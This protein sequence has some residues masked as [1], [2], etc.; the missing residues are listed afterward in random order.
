MKKIVPSIFCFLC[1]FSLF[2]LEPAF[3]Q[4][5]QSDFKNF[6]VTVPIKLDLL[7]ATQHGMFNDFFLTDQSSVILLPSSETTYSTHLAIEA[8]LYHNKA[9]TIYRSFFARFSFKGSVEQIEEVSLL[10]GLRWKLGY[11][12]RTEIGFAPIGAFGLLTPQFFSGGGIADFKWHNKSW[13]F[14]AHLGFC[15]NTRYAASA[16]YGFGKGNKKGH[17]FEIEVSCSQKEAYS[18]FI[19]LFP[20]KRQA[21]TVLSVDLGVRDPFENSDIQKSLFFRVGALHRAFGRGRPGN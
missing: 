17:P 18:S 6:K 19:F 15:G 13:R 9:E 16:A 12:Q 10:A 14:A 5:G 20:G 21:P 8:L 4:G 1:F 3:S 2:C 11:L 7:A